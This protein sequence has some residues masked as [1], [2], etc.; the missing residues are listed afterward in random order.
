MKQSKQL[1]LKDIALSVPDFDEMGQVYLLFFHL[2]YLLPRF[3]LILT[4]LVKYR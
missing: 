1:L 3:S 4:C 2:C